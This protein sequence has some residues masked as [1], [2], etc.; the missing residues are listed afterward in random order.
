MNEAALK[1]LAIAVSVIAG[2]FMARGLAAPVAG[3]AAAH[4]HGLAAT[5]CHVEGTIA[6]DLVAAVAD[7]LSE[8][9]DGGNGGSGVG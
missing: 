7:V 5:R 2:A 3:A 4:V 1:P 6:R 9:H 8:I